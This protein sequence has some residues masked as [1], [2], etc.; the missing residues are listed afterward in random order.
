MPDSPDLTPNEISTHLC[1]AGLI[2]RATAVILEQR[3]VAYA[4]RHAAQARS[5]GRMEAIREA[6]QKAEGAV[7]RIKGERQKAIAGRVI[8]AV[9][10]MLPERAAADYE[11]ARAKEQSYQH[12]LRD[13][14][15][16]ADKEKNPKGQR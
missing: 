4:D 10:S 12:G 13:G 16:S 3:I 7:R 11:L 1:D 15:A 9:K 6:L 8:W 2:D 14:K 5:E